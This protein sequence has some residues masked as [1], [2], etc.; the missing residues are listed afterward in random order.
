MADRVS[1]THLA[2]HSKEG[3][4]RCSSFVQARISFMA[5]AN[6]AVA[7]VADWERSR[8]LVDDSSAGLKGAAHHVF[9]LRDVERFRQQRRAQ[10]KWR[11]APKSS[12]TGCQNERD[13]PPREFIGGRKY[14]CITRLDVQPHAVHVVRLYRPQSLVEVRQP[15]GRCFARVRRFRGC[16]LF[17]VVAQY[18]RGLGMFGLGWR[19]PWDGG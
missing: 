9:Q 18:R 13:T 16:P 3:F 8:T 6:A 4:A 17:Y 12:S 5:V 11:K 7:E 1:S 14:V 15:P 10:E 19:P 2:Q